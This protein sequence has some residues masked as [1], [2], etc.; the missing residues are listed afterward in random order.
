MSRS[1]TGGVRSRRGMS[2]A[3]AV[4]V[5]VIT[6]VVLG[7]ISFVVFNTPSKTCA[8]STSPA[9]TK[10]TNDHD[11]SVLAPFTN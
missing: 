11:V 5:L 9:C 3:T 7:A 10:V 8:P 4:V 6:I 2:S 1:L